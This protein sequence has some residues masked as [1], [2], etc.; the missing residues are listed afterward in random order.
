[1]GKIPKVTLIEKEHLLMWTRQR[2][3]VLEKD[4]GIIADINEWGTGWRSNVDDGRKDAIVDE[5]NKPNIHIREEIDPIAFPFIMQLRF[6]CHRQATTT[7]PPSIGAFYSP[8]RRH[9]RRTLLLIMMMNFLFPHSL[10][11]TTSRYVLLCWCCWRTMSR[12]LLLLFGALCNC[13]L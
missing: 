6:I 12:C 7:P 3:T 4:G 13:K 1:M 2:A 5:F 11:F 9:Q 8:D 10:S